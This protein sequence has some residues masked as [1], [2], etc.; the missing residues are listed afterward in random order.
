MK[1]TFK[2]TYEEPKL[3][4]I[5]FCAQDILSSSIDPFFGEDDV[6]ELA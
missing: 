1:N 3:Q 6:F 2:M 5:T 4:I